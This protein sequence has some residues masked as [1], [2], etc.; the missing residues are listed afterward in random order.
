MADNAIFKNVFI[1]IVMDVYKKWTNYIVIMYAYY[2]NFN[3]KRT[4]TTIKSHI[5]GKLDHVT[6]TIV[7]NVCDYC[8]CRS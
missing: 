8:F 5:W 2:L 1:Q 3:G 4:R 7:I 6:Q